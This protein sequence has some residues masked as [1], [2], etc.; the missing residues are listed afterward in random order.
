MWRRDLA[1]IGETNN[2]R[3]AFL[4]R[5]TKNTLAFGPK[6][7]QLGEPIPY[8]YCVPQLESRTVREVGVDPPF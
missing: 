6:G 8:D 5:S 1:E 7:A 4:L 2:D 3:V